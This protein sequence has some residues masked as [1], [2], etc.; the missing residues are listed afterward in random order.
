MA[1]RGETEV[2]EQTVQSVPKLHGLGWGQ[3][4]GFG[5]DAREGIIHNDARSAVLL[6][7][8][9]KWGQAEEW[10]VLHL[11][12]RQYGPVAKTN[13]V[14]HFGLEELGMGPG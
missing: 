1:W 9:T 3:A 7:D 13:E 5:V 12:E 14:E 4:G 11:P 10:Q 6:W 8:D 2:T